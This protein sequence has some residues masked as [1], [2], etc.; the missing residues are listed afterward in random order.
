MYGDYPS[1]GLLTA[2]DESIVEKLDNAYSPP[3]LVRYAFDHAVPGRP[4]TNASS[5][6]NRSMSGR[7]GVKVTG[8]GDI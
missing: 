3:R 2:S 6:E 8:L 7:S 5:V 1:G 4:S